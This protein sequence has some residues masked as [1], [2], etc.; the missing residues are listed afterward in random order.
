MNCGNGK[1][2]QLNSLGKAHTC[3]PNV[4]GFSHTFSPSAARYYFLMHVDN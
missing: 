1:M 2:L 4:L 3:A